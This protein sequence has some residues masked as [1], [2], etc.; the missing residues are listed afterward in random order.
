MKTSRNAPCPCGS[1]HKYKVCCLQKG[2]SY[3]PTER[4][5]VLMP[6]RDHVTEPTQRCLDLFTDGNVEVLTEVGLPVDVARNRLI[7][8][9]KS[10][11][12]RPRYVIWTDADAVWTS[13]AFDILRDSIRKCGPHALI[14][15]LH[16]P[17]C[18]RAEAAALRVIHPPTGTPIQWGIDYPVHPADPK[19]LIRVAFV[20][21]HMLAHDVRLLDALKSH[22]WTPRHRYECSEDFAFTARVY[23]ARGS[24]WCHAGLLVFHYDED[25]A[26]AFAPGYLPPFMIDNT[27]QPQPMADDGTGWANLRQSNKRS[28][29]STVDAQM[30]RNRILATDLSSK[31]RGSL[32]T[33][34]E[35]AA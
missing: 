26:V 18:V 30:E 20:G 8:R 9:V 33:G 15:V 17:R 16:G 23:E 5:V 3:T 14:G 31:G 4:T 19:A 11:A 24:V 1:G 10:L 27:G 28:Y 21:A 25:R 35:G 6:I 2:D 13:G 32:Y 29:G 22:P 34:K 12:D 7:E